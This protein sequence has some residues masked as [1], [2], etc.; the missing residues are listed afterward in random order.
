M[1][2][3]YTGTSMSRIENTRNV[4]S[5]TC[6]CAKCYHSTNKK[7]VIYCSYYD[8]IN[9]KKRKCARYF[10]MD[11]TKRKTKEKVKRVKKEPTFPW[12]LP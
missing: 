8:L 9:P 5:I 7:G 4:K 2:N 11:K 1:R 3:S 12:E 6:D 10:E